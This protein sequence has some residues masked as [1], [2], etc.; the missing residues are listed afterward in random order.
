MAWATRK[1]KKWVGRYRDEAGKQRSTARVS[2]KK[3]ALQLAHAEEMKIRQG[4][5]NDPTAGSITFR[6]YFEVHWLPHR[7]L[8]KNRRENYRSFF[9]TSYEPAFGDMQLRKITPPIVQ[10]WVSSEI[11]RGTSPRTLADKATALSTILGSTKGVSAMRDGL[12]RTNPVAGVDLPAVPRRTV[13]IYEVDEFDAL[14]EHLQPYDLVAVLAAETGFRWGELMGLRVSSFSRDRQYVTAD[15]VII[16]L[17]KEAIGNGSRFEWKYSTKGDVD[18]QVAISPEVATLVDA[19]IRAHGL[20]PHDRL[21]S[22]LDSAGQV[23]RTDAWPEGLPIG[24]SNWRAFWNKAH[25]KAGIPRRRFHDVR[26]SHITWLLSGGADVISVQ[27]R[28]GHNNLSTTQKYAKAMRDAD[29][30]N[31]AALA[32]TRGRARSH[33][34]LVS[35]GA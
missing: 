28:V 3:E 7:T 31:L 21:L 26:A 19:H 9:R 20:Q 32:R 29:Q 2:T 35:D 8:S 14:L 16:E 10:R 5:W 23:K 18:R 34:A 17:S 13:K 12:I 4:E 6:E 22:R 30:R 27:E 25:E 33:L 15:A 11:A 1:D 24:R